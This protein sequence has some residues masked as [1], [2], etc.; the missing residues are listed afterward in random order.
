[1]KCHYAEISLYRT[2]FKK[3]SYTWN[4]IQNI[5]TEMYFFP[6]EVFKRSHRRRDWIIWHCLAPR[7]GDERG[8][9]GQTTKKAIA[10][11]QGIICSVSLWIGTEI[12]HFNWGKEKSKS[13]KKWNF[14]KVRTGQYWVR[15]PEQALKFLTL[16]TLKQQQGKH[17]S[18]RHTGAA[19]PGKET[20]A[21]IYFCHCGFLR[22]SS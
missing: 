10:Q 16:E 13:A 17:L 19:D 6:L 21:G 20:K 14:L 11:R 9:K 18:W 7:K 12:T 8:T 5:S 4:I 3:I 2:F 22:L 15:L 1:M